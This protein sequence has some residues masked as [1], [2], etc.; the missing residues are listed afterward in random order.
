M[1][2]IERCIYNGISEC[3]ETSYLLHYF[4][5][6]IV[7][8]IPFFVRSLYVWFVLVISP[9]EHHSAPNKWRSTK[10]SRA[11]LFYSFVYYLLFSRRKKTAAKSNNSATS[12]DASGYATA[13]QYL[14]DGILFG[15][16][17][18]KNENGVEVI[19]FEYYNHDH[20][21]AY[22][23]DYAYVCTLQRIII[24]II[25]LASKCVRWCNCADENGNSNTS[26]G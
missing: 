3:S 6:I 11:S 17:T 1:S 10:R 18:M 15:R 14:W 9:R 21:N 13:K 19:Y 2:R 22:N 16:S 8:L 26:I 20:H 4:K 7:V 24:I 5:M 23:C 12:S 25:S